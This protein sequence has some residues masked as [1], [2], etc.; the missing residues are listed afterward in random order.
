MHQ[1]NSNY[2]KSD[3]PT[4][5]VRVITFLTL[6][7]NERVYCFK[8]NN[9]DNISK[10]FDVTPNVNENDG[11]CIF[12]GC[13]NK[14]ANNYDPRANLDDGSCLFYGCTDNKYDN[15]DAQANY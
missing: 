15:Y 6:E 4:D 3:N 1:I 11:S 8:Q 9:F 2:L 5:E 12:P 10:T 13:I 7:N 14:I